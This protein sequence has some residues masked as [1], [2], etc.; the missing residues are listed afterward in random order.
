MTI[1]AAPHLS[2]RTD[3]RATLAFTR[4]GD[5]TRVTTAQATS[6]LRLLI[7]QIAGNSA[8]AAW[9]FTSS[10]G[11]GLLAG[12]RIHLDVAVH[13]GA[14]AYV[15]TQ[16]STKIYRS[17]DHRVAHQSL[18]ATLQDNATLLLAPD[19]VV[20]FKDARYQQHQAFH[21][22]SSANLLLLDWFTAGRHAT[23]ERWQFHSFLTRNEIFVGGNRVLTDALRLDHHAGPLDSPSRMGPFNVFATL[24]LLGPRLQ[25]AAEAML[26]HVANL[27]VRR[28]DPLP[29][30][31]SA[32]ARAPG[33][34]LR[35][36]APTTELA[37]HELYRHLVCLADL[38]GEHPWL[39]KW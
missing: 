2:T 33:A 12:D 4:T 8:A 38:L 27:P 29:L 16:S 1:L 21:L 14:T 35:L 32:L 11:G 18:T 37:A 34:I 24:L 13:E 39:R 3:G 31:A 15:S 6:P 9:A 5:Q 7:P 20:P 22:A 26:A 10:F 36:A 28:R 30:S 23:G 19:P 25:P 17:A